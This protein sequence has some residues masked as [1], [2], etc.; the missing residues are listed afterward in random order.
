MS[1]NWKTRWCSLLLVLSMLTGLCAP[2]YAES[3]NGPDI[4]APETST[5]QDSSVSADTEVNDDTVIDEDFVTT[6][7]NELDENSEITEEPEINQD[8]VTIAESGDVIWSSGFDTAVENSAWDGGQAP[9]GFIL[10]CAG[11][12]KDAKIELDATEF[13]STPYAVHVT[14]VGAGRTGFQHDFNSLDCTKNYV[15]TAWVKTANSKSSSP[16]WKGPRFEIQF[17]ESKANP[18]SVVTPAIEGTSD[19]YKITLD[20]PSE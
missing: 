16:S 4:P 19:W 9:E 11:T 1:K 8:S 18:K 15:F 2:A 6:E 20:M 7:E 10:A 12:K 3:E 5:E 14:G 13:H 17:Y